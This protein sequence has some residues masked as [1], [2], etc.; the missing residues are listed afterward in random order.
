MPAVDL[1]N[2]CRTPHVP[3]NMGVSRGKKASSPTIAEKVVIVVMGQRE[4]GVVESRTQVR[5]PS[6]I[7]TPTLTAGDAIV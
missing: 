2:T 3:N 6:K 7:R 1:M 5:K 4:G